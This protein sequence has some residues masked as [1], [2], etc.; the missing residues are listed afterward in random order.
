MLSHPRTNFGS[1]STLFFQASCAS[2]G[3]SACSRPRAR[4]PCVSATASGRSTS[5]ASCLPGWTSGTIS[6][7]VTRDHHGSVTHA[8][9]LFS[10]RCSRLLRYGCS[11]L[12]NARSNGFERLRV[13]AC[14]NARCIFKGN[15][16]TPLAGYVALVGDLSG[17]SS[18]AVVR[19]S[20]SSMATCSS[21]RA[22]GAPGHAWIPK[23]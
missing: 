4:A 6:S 23:P 22:S 15:A 14:Y 8:P 12:P 1:A 3:R 11:T 16:E 2:T 18:I 20:S 17:A 5:T 10:Y 7:G 21:N 13:A 9:G 19:L